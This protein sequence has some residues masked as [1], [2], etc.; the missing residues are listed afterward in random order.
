M[1]PEQVDKIIE[2]GRTVPLI[3]SGAVVSIFA[4][5]KFF[6]HLNVKI[7]EKSVGAA[8]VKDL[9]DCMEELKNEFGMFKISYKNQDVKIGEL[10]SDNQEI[11]RSNSELVQTILKFVN[12]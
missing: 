1:T 6:E 10:H 3:V 2:I 7:R 8:A 12:R 5:I 11:K 9:K 4:V